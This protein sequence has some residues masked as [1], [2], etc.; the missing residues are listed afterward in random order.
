[1][2]YSSCAE[3]QPEELV[4]GAA[5]PSVVNPS[6][7]MNVTFLPLR[8][9][10]TT[11]VKP[12]D[13]QPSKIPADVPLPV[14]AAVEVCALEPIKNSRVSALRIFG[15]YVMFLNVNPVRVKLSPS[16]ETVLLY[17]RVYSTYRCLPVASRTGV[18]IEFCIL[19]INSPPAIFPTDCVYLSC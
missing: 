8:F 4:S 11:A 2:P 7:G 3:D 17:L 5:P 9:Q 15:S 6:S 18:N 12:L 13:V 16:S 14:P 10:L 1:M 19:L